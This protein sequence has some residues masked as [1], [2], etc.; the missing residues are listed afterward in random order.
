MLRRQLVQHELC[1]GT[2]HH[3]QVIEIVGH[4][5]GQLA[6]GIQPLGLLE[7]QLKPAP[8]GNIAIVRNEVGDPSI[9]VPQRCDRLFRIEDVSIF[10][11]IDHDSTEHVARENR[12]P[13]VVIE[14]RGLVSRLEQTR[15]SPNR[16]FT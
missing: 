14:L 13:Q 7:L 16:L 2:D 4:S 3:Q 11:S 15:R 6:Y 1:I 8:L 12:L 10:L 5:S 9:R